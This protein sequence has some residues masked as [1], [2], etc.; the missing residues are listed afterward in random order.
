MFSPSILVALL[1]LSTLV[2]G[3]PLELS[4]RQ[5]KC[6]PNFEGVGVSVIWDQL[7]FNS[8][9]WAPGAV[10]ANITTV[11]NDIQQAAKFRFEQTG[12]W[13]PTY[14]AKKSGVPANNQVVSVGTSVTNNKFLKIAQSSSSDPNQTWDISCNICGTNA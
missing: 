6:H 7:P 11:I 9:E 10:G 3:S 14:V 5:I 4:T 1:A 8:R 2:S 12:A 13:P